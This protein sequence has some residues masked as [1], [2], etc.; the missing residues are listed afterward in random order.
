ML[1]LAELRDRLLGSPWNPLA[2]GAWCRR[3]RRQLRAPGHAVV[4]V[5]GETLPWAE[6]GVRHGYF[7]MQRMDGLPYLRA[8]GAPAT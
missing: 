8:L 3:Q 4:W 5:R 1:D 7:E 6:W 2:R